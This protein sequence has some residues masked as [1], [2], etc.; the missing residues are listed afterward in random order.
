LYEIEFLLIF[1]IQIDFDFRKMPQPNL[2][3]GQ[4]QKEFRVSIAFGAVSGAVLTTVALTIAYAWIFHVVDSKDIANFSLS[5]LTATT[6]AASA[7]YVGLQLQQ[8]SITLAKSTEEEK[9]TRTISYAARWNNPE[10]SEI[11]YEV[12]TLVRYIV[13]KQNNDSVIS[14]I[15]DQLKLKPK[16]E[17]Y[18]NEVLNFFEE[19]S[20]W[21]EKDIIDENTL[22]DFYLTI[23]V[24]YYAVF[25]P[26]IQEKRR[27][28]G[29]RLFKSFENLYNRWK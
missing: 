14:L 29:P 18:L 25:E 6:T 11:K 20:V 5:A 28:R 3:T 7:F 23:I 13:S 24:R 12:L 9:I 8:A 17:S 27:E 16:L 10:F 26:W 2:P 4:I 1:P 22:K 15:N 21:V 19:M